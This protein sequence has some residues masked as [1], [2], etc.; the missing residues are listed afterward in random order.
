MLSSLRR[1]DTRLED[2]GVRS[3]LVGVEVLLFSG[4]LVSVLCS[5]SLVSVL[6]SSLSLRSFRETCR[7]LVYRESLMFM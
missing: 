2:G 5:K 3:F 7:W 6:A 4:S 1:L